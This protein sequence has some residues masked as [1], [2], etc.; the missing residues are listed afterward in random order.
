MSGSFKRGWRLPE[1]AEAEQL[2]REIYREH[3]SL[4]LTTCERRLSDHHA[5]EDATAEV[6][7]IAW[8]KILDGK[9]VD[10]PW[11]YRTA[12]NVVGNE[13][14][15]RG[16][17][18]ALFDKTEE[19]AR[20]T[21]IATPERS[22]ETLAALSRLRLDDREILFMAYWEDLSSSEMAAILRLRETTV[23]MRI[24]RARAALRRV[25]DQGTGEREEVTPVG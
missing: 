6:F 7:R 1:R 14:R 20:V 23:R 11:L 3:R 24:S 25:L 21:G 15:R 12:R 5:A 10:L 22:I 13:Y 16:R 18:Q 17:A 19:L 4:I 8:Q 2:F 9:R